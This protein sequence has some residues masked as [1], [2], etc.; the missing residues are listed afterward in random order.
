MEI[1]L[2]D[3]GMAFKGLTV[4]QFVTEVAE[5]FGLRREDVEVRAGGSSS[6]GRIRGPTYLMEDVAAADAGFSVVLVKTEVYEY[7]RAN[8]TRK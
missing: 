1:V 3:V 2:R 7:T 6:L 4:K 5:Y 8:L